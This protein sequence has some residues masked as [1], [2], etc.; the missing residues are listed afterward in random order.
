MAF[1]YFFRDEHT[2]RQAIRLMLPQVAGRQRIRIWDAG[3]AMGQEPYTLAILMAEM[4]G[5][6]SFRNVMI[7]ATDLDGSRLFG[8]II[9]RAEYPKTELERIPQELRERYFEAAENSEHLRLTEIIKTRLRFT[10]HDLLT[11]CPAGD[12]YSMVLCKNVLL[13]FTAQQRAEIIRMFNRSLAENGL[14]VFEQTQ[15]LPEELTPFFERIAGDAQIF[16]KRVK[17]T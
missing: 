12:E 14:L 8:E 4:M 2:L 13:H 11:L 6:Y 3:C 15:S 1:T 7:D 5:R 17:V 9:G 16:R 10:R